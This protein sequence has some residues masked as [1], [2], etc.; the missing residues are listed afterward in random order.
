MTKEKNYLMIFII[1]I[2]PFLEPSLFR[3]YPL[4]H[5]V[6]MVYKITSAA[7]IIINYVVNYVIKGKISKMMILIVLY[8]IELL[9]STYINNGDISTAINNFIAII[10]VAALIEY[11]FKVDSKISFAVIYYI[12]G[13]YTVL[14]FFNVIIETHGSRIVN[15][16]MIFLLGIDNRFIFTYLPMICFGLIYNH[17]ANKRNGLLLFFTSTALL[18][19]LYSW[20]VGA[21]FGMILLVFYIIF[22]LNKKYKNVK[23]TFKYYFL[24]IIILNVLI[25]LFQFQNY[26]AGLINTYLG[27]DVTFSG[28]TFLWELGI[29]K[30]KENPLLGYGI[31]EEMVKEELYGLE[32]FHNY[33]VNLMY[34]GGILSFAI[35]CMMNFVAINK[36]TKF[37]NT[38]IARVVSSVIFVS[39]ILS[40]VDTLDY[41]YFFIF[42]LI[43]GNIEKLVGEKDEQE[44]FNID[45]RTSI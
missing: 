20:S 44:R 16:S 9:L 14:N 18:T 12:F 3:E 11:T 17:L 35:F 7:I 31:N 37:K 38:Y 4:V 21:L 42:Y 36:L 28:R 5:K 10:T 2:I 24:I 26:F 39:L 6:F 43:A 34:Q 30:I 33:F 32:H 1:L 29:T 13:I 40:L 25:V 23:M 41:T 15:G 27:K 8:Q 45:N 22:D 19:V